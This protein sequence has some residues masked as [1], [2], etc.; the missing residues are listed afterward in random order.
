MVHACNSNTGEVVETC[1][2]QGVTHQ[3]AYI[4]DTGSY[5]PLGDTVPKQNNKTL[6]VDDS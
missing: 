5:G 1:G 2:S 3:S 6:D 4:A